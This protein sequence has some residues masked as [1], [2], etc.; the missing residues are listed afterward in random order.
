MTASIE[1]RGETYQ[2]TTPQTMK[3]V[4]DY[5]H[6]DP[7]SYFLLRDGRL[8]D[9]DEMVLDNDVVQLIPMVAGG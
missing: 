8:L 2:V 3:Q 7:E 4:L 6:L 9:T 1:F 5:M